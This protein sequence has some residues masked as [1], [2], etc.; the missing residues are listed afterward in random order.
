M[1]GTWLDDWLAQNAPDARTAMRV[2]FDSVLL[3]E[4]VAAG[5]G[6]HFLATFD[7]DGDDNLV[8]IG[9]VQPAFGRDIWLLTLP[10]LRQTSRVRAF[11]DHVEERL[12]GDGGFAR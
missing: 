2:D 4:A 9:P 8:R 10:E 11:I 6:V 5:I 1:N 12:R 3:R 7:A